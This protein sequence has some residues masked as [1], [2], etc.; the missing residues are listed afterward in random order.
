MK[1]F[2]TRDLKG[3]Q[4]KIVNEDCNLA[5]KSKKGNQSSMARWGEVKKKRFPMDGARGRFTDNN[6]QLRGGEEWE[7]KMAREM[8]GKRRKRSPR[9]G[10]LWGEKKSRRERQLNR[11]EPGLR[12]KGILKKKKSGEKNK[13]RPSRPKKRGDELGR[14]AWIEGIVRA[15][16]FRGAWKLNAGE[17]NDRKSSSGPPPL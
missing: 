10:K 11:R 5:G 15:K 7:G 17:K 16:I 14:S 6:F 1:I 9:G 8:H 12:D 4:D 3:R 2:L 13:E